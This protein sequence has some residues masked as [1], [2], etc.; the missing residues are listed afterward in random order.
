MI[1]W[2]PFDSEHRP[3]P[4]A[5]CAIYSSTT[6]YVSFGVLHE[7]GKVWLEASTSRLITQKVTHWSFINLPGEEEA[8]GEGREST[9]KED[10][11]DGS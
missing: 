3:E 6:R 7:N 1:E 9:P 11:K 10:T 4:G 8:K 2:I 5:I